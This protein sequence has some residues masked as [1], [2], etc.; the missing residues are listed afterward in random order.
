MG[1]GFAGAKKN[2]H[3]RVAVKLWKMKK[4]PSDLWQQRPLFAG[5]AGRY[6]KL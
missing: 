1:L 4:I 5:L 6:Q 3:P 2:G